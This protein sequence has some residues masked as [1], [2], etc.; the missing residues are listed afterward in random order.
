MVGTFSRGLVTDVRWNDHFTPVSQVSVNTFPDTV[1]TAPTDATR[2][3][4][5][6]NTRPETSLDRHGSLRSILRDRN[7]PATGQ[8]VRFFSRDGYKIMTPESST[9]SDQDDSPVSESLRRKETT[10][11]VELS[12]SGS[13]GR[14]R[15]RAPVQGLFVP[16]QNPSSP[17]SS[18]SVVAQSLGSM[19]P[20]SPPEV[21]NIFDMSH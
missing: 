7:T 6:S 20:M 13:R 18:P 17:P 5:D 1:S 9:M 21:T 16:T 2:P 14:H 8:S 10:P 12:P 19:M 3:S 4:I 15:F 11:E